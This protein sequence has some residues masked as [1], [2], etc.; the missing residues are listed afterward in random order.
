MKMIVLREKMK[1]TVH[2]DQELD[3]DQEWNLVMV[4]DYG[5]FPESRPKHMYLYV[6]VFT[7]V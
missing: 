6:F 3:L 4:R 5:I 1:M 7:F 2:Q